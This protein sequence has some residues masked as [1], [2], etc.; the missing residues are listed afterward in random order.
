[1]RFFLPV[2]LIVAL[3]S[4]VRPEEAPEKLCSALPDAARKNIQKYFPQHDLKRC[5]CF[6]AM[7][8][9][10]CAIHTLQKDSKFPMLLFGY[11]RSNGQ[12][13]DSNSIN[14]VSPEDFEK[15]FSPELLKKVRAGFKAKKLTFRRAEFFILAGY[16]IKSIQFSSSPAKGEGCGYAGE[17]TEDG[18]VIKKT[19]KQE[20]CN[21]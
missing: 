15:Y 1:M 4:S 7:I 21:P 8:G 16:K 9:Y 6:E 19:A 5:S 10:Q 18:K 13:D 17:Y 14:T 20:D 3:F 2:L 12:I 11:D